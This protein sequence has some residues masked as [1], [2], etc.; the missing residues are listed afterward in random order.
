MG[1]FG[2]FRSKEAPPPEPPKPES[3]SIRPELVEIARIISDGDEVV[4]QEITACTQDPKGWFAAHQGQ[5]EERGI[6]STNDLDSVQWLGLVDILE[7]HNWLCE[8]DWKDELED[9]LFFLQ[10]LKGYQA[11]G[12]SLNPEWLDPEE[13]IPS[14]CGI[15]ADKWNEVRVAAIDIDSDSY[16][17]FPISVTQLPQLQ[18]LA[19]EIGHRIDYIEGM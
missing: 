1:L 16:V 13:D 6:Y 15:L 7:S 14:W 4:S 9:F 17:L 11:L 5:Y 18:K 8:R 2:M 3:K 12:L 19:G 10:K